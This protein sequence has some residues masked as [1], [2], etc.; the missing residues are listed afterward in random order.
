MIMAD[1]GK[2]QFFFIEDSVTIWASM[3]YDTL[4]N[5]FL[6]NQTISKYSITINMIIIFM[7]FRIT[8]IIISTFIDNYITKMLKKQ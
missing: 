6:Q 7:I 2:H 3:M 8:H 5:F 4:F 1:V